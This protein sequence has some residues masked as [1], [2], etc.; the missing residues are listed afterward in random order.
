MYQRD[1]V[2]QKSFN[3]VNELIILV[4]YYLKPLNKALLSALTF[5]Q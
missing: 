2:L 4:T 3:K 1:C 5:T